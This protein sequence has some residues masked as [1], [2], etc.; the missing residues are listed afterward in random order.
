MKPKKCVWSH[1]M[2]MSFQGPHRSTH[3]PSVV[4]FP[5]SETRDWTRSPVWVTGLRL[6]SHFSQSL[7]LPQGLK[8]L[9]LT[10]FRSWESFPASIMER[11]LNT[12]VALCEISTTV[13]LLKICGRMWGPVWPQEN[14]YTNK[15]I[16]GAPWSRSGDPFHECVFI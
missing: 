6:P 11:A 2:I 10:H 3:F 13:H 8:I 4:M 7:S 1:P 5:G 16:K 14:D 12:P 9:S 15:Q